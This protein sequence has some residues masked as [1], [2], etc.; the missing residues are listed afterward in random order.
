MTLA[1]PG[2]DRDLM[3]TMTMHSILDAATSGARLGAAEALALCDVDD[4]GPLMEAA[5]DVRDRRSGDVV[6]FSPKVFIPLTEL[7]R[8]VCHYCT[9]AKT[10]GN[11]PA[12]YLSV[13]EAVD[14]A[15][16][17]AEAGCTEALFTL[18]DQPER[19]YRAAREVLAAMGFGSTIDYLVHA[20]RRVHEETGLLPHV[21]PGV[22]SR[23]E[24][25]RLREVSVSAGIMLES[26]ARRLGEKGGPHYGS[27]DKDPQVRLATLERAGEL[28]VPFTTGILIGIGETRRERIES[29]L[30]IRDLDERFGHV[31][32]AIIQNFR[33]KPGTPMAQ[34][35]EPTLDDHLWTIAASR[36]IL[37]EGISVQAPPNLRPG[38]LTRLLE[39]G[40]DDWGGVSPVTPDHVN[41]EAPWPHLAELERATESAGKSLAPRL[42]IHPR[43][44][45]DLERWVDPGLHGAVLAASDGQ[46]LGRDS[47]W[48]AGDA[49]RTGVVREVFHR[50]IPGRSSNEHPA[51]AT[52]TSQRLPAVAAS[53]RSSNEHPA[54][55]TH[56]PERREADEVPHWTNFTA[57]VVARRASPSLGRVLDRVLEGAPLDEARIVRLFEARGG[58]ARA[59]CEAADRLRRERNGDAVSYVVNRNINYTNVCYFKCRFCAFS[60]GR[61]SANL[62]GRPYDLDLAEIA[63]RTREAWSRGAT[64]VCLQGG[65]HPDYTGETYL[66]ICRAVKDAAP[67]IH[68]HA[69]SPLEVWQGA[70]TLGI[71]LADYIERLRTAGLG[72]LPGT[73]AEILDDEVRA[74]ICPDKITTGEWLEVMESAHT[75]GLGSTATIMFGHVDG[76]RHWARHLLRVRELA[77][78]TGGFTEFV[79]LAFVHME[80]PMYLRGRARRGPTLREAVLMHAVARLVLDP[81]VV[82]I[83]V[84]WVKMGPD[85]VRLALAAGA[86]DV[87]GTLMNESITRAAGAGFGQEMPPERLESIIREAGRSPRQR[88]TRYRDAPAERIHA[89][90]G[91]G[92]LSEP[93]NRRARRF[94]RDPSVPLVRSGAG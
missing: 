44:V 73:A 70:R 43:Y 7:C 52:P 2:L 77:A 50:E 75:V 25:A 37:G 46:G 87:G 67:G 58:E 17:G 93:V 16:R 28:A 5:R 61:L 42:P 74:V 11:V 24:L 29:L 94:E 20:A 13:D 86:N 89:S 15:R 83:Q 79:P 26:T 48:F 32:E 68:V 71:G 63:R 72:S 49:E 6:T 35:P 12:P 33:A 56:A 64:E 80:S 85:G 57:G 78:R 53:G 60:K 81:L 4:L 36:L 14:I 45:D 10:P 55:A 23:E 66:S 30:A 18:G 65:I 90:I 27:P 3:T 1:E 22:M 41:P 39:A 88:T 51:D 38:V 47:D 69:F 9:F 19:R 82:N 84:S 59:V 62:R 76:Y 54:D 8:D 40:V 21:N 92:A 91:A 31:Q 34:A